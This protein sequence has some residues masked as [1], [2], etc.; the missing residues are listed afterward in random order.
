MAFQIKDIEYLLE[1]YNNGQTTLKEEQQLKDYFAQGDVAPHLK[2]YKIMFNFFQESKKE[3]YTKDIIFKPKLFNS[4]KWIPVAAI[5]TLMLSL[6][7]L[8]KPNEN[9]GLEGLSD[10]EL[11]VYQQTK[12]AFDLLSSKLNKGVQGFNTLTLATENLEK[13]TKQIA[14]INEFG[15]ITN[16]IFKK[17]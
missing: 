5:I 16:K 17:N 11:L 9:I 14:L 4:H 8:N 3:R 6:V 12:A 1:K 2:H 10:E 15:N 13:G 7:F